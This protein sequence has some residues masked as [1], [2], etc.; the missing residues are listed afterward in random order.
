M[1]ICIF[2]GHSDC[3]GL[4]EKILESAIEEIILKGVDTFYV[5]HQGDFDCMAL[6][7]LK[8][9]K[10]KHPNITYMVV[11]AYIPTYKPEY[12]LYH[13]CSMYPEGLEIGPPRFA[14]ER[15]NKWLI[16]CADY[17]IAYINHSWG[18][19]YKFAK[20]A[21][22]KGIDISNIGSLDL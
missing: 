21:K 19:A 14:I 20:R 18:G 7:A 10:E 12:D 11:L 22:R 8:T 17:C 4:D 16:D 9:L 1:S 2:F 13:G 6:K 3:Y 5:G 15:R